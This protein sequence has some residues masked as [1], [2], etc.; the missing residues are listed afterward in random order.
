RYDKN[1]NVSDV[2]R[3]GMNNL[4][5]YGVIDSLEITRSGNQLV[6]I[7]DHAEKN[8]TYTGASDFVDG[9]NIP[10]E[11]TYD[12][13]GRLTMDTNRGIGS[14]TYDQC[15]NPQAIAFSGTN[16]ID[17]VYAPDGTRLRTVHVLS[18]IGGSVTRDTT[19]YLGNLV[20]RDSHLGMYRFDGGY[21]SF[22]NDTIDGWHL[23]ISDY[24]GNNRL[25][26]RDSII[27]QITHY[28]P[29]GGVI[30]DISTN[31]NVQKY[32]FEGKE[33]DRTF[34]LDNYDI[35]A[36]QYFAMAP[37][38]DRIDPMTE[39]NPQF[40][41]YSYCMGDPV[42]LGDY[43]GLDTLYFKMNKDGKTANYDNKII[44]DG[45]HIG[46]IKTDSGQIIQFSFVY[47]KDADRFKKK[48]NLTDEDILDK[49]LL[50][51]VSLI[52]KETLKSQIECVPGWL[53]S[54]PFGYRYLSLA[55]AFMQS[56]GTN[57]TLDFVNYPLIQDRPRHL[58]IPNDNTNIAHDS[59]NFGNYLWGAGMRRLGIP[60]SVSLIGGNI[61]SLKHNNLQFDSIDDMK[62][63]SLGYLFCPQP[64]LFKNYFGF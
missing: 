40:S 2:A 4:R 9:T 62:S 6:A 55:Y 16:G 60:L 33:L 17:Y 11:Y 19:D 52:D 30:G 1:S 56:R 25:V 45:K 24:M 12:G 61:D 53:G 42:N 46:I 13:N 28:Y 21:V 38:W 43:N 37:T 14:I 34:G 27:E 18:G 64:S 39:D 8:L 59:F 7:E 36:R 10:Q 57:G 26:V 20:M 49:S 41:P 48:D 22:S 35:H 5:G 23:Y 54:L 50:T 63:I 15:N 31:E 51:G 47:Q 3:Y 29:Y 44:S 32:K 58:F